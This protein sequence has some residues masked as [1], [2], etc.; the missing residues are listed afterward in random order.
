MNRK[1]PSTLSITSF[2]DDGTPIWGFIWKHGRQASQH[3]HPN[4]HNWPDARPSRQLLQDHIRDH[5]SQILPFLHRITS[6]P[7][8]PHFTQGYAI[9]HP[10][11]PLSRNSLRIKELL[12]CE[13]C[14]LARIFAIG[15]IQCYVALTEIGV[16]PWTWA[17]E[18]V[19][20][21]GGMTRRR[22][23]ME[24]SWGQVGFFSSPRDLP[25]LQTCDVWVGVGFQVHGWFARICICW[26]EAERDLLIG[27][28]V[29]DMCKSFYQ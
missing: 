5:L 13:N 24:V 18:G 10:L 2:S 11:H 21:A 23:V 9:F 4:I 19:W 14:Y 28:K 27:T 29:F 16:H 1:L 20:S 15:P 17:S 8:R 3:P 6:S 7:P 26:A 12:I 25:S 22:G